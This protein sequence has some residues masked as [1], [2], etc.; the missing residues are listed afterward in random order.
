MIDTGSQISIIKRECIPL[1]ITE[2]KEKG[3][4]E[5][6]GISGGAINFDTYVIIPIKLTDFRNQMKKVWG[7]F[8][9]HDVTETP[10]IL[11]MDIL[12]QAGMM[13]YG[14]YAPPRIVS[15]T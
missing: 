3:E 2:V 14:R 6:M 9:V 13:I 12:H 10:N 8:L 7:K 15:Q 4:R 11:G 5:F 1:E